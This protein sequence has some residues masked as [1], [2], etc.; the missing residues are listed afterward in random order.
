MV[1]FPIPVTAPLI[2][3]NLVSVTADPSVHPAQAAALAAGLDLPLVVPPHPV[4]TPYLLAL[5][6]DR[7]ELRELGPGAPGPVY[8]DFVAGAVAHR[9]LFGGGRGQPL[10]RAIG[11]KRGATPTV[12]DA[13][14][15][16]G[17]DAFVLACLGCTVHL[18]E[19]SPIIAALL[20]DGLERAVLDAVIGALVAER[21]QLQVADAQRYLRQLDPD[22]HPDVVYLDPM[23][24]HRRKSALVGKE[25]RLLRQLVGD[26]EDA[27]E[28][29]AAALCCA[30][31]RVVVKR[32]RLAPNLEG[33]P[34]T[35][36]I[37]APNTR[38][39]VYLSPRG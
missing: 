12:I 16:L 19:R 31:Q 14:A 29:L 26:D 9:R 13:T 38:F 35:L 5:M 33:P 21:M 28:L 17:R 20:R 7:L 22:Q 25:M 27:S 3:P 10:A 36:A 34:P 18:L 37:T 23:Y 8:V 15:G 30:R 6:P 24:P 4:V 11:L 2:P 32:P 1:S 39:D